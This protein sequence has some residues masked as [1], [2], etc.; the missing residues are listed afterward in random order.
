MLKNTFRLLILTFFITSFLFAQQEKI[1]QVTVDVVDDR[2]VIGYDFLKNYVYRSSK[3]TFKDSPGTTNYYDVSLTVYD[4][5]KKLVEKN[6]KSKKSIINGDIGLSI[7]SGNGK[8]IFWDV[9]SDEIELVGDNLIFTIEAKKVEKL[10]FVNFIIPGLY[11]YKVQRKP[12]IFA[13]SFLFYS[14]LIAGIV[15][16]NI[17]SN[18]YEKYNNATSSVDI[19]N[20]YNNANVSLQWAYLCYTLSATITLDNIYNIFKRSPLK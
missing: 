14:S 4:G 15:F 12:T 17:S 20:Y 2:L 6:H 5:N 8:R 18:E 16:N 19:E 1:S 3:S 10:K 7:Q 13:K 11:Q 9:F